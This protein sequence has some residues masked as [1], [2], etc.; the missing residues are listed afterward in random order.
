MKWCLWVPLAAEL[1]AD[2]LENLNASIQSAVNQYDEVLF[3]CHKTVRDHKRRVKYA[4]SDLHHADLEV[5][6]ATAALMKSLGDQHAL[7]T[8]LDAGEFKRLKHI[9]HCDSL[10][11]S[12]LDQLKILKN[13]IDLASAMRDLVECGDATSKTAFAVC[14]EK[15]VKL[16]NQP[17]HP[18]VSSQKKALLEVVGGPKKCALGNNINCG[19]LTDAVSHLHGAA[20]DNTQVLRAQIAAHLEFCKKQLGDMDSSSVL[21]AHRLDGTGS[22]IA[23]RASR[24]VDAR[25][26]QADMH[27]RRHEATQV[28]EDAVSYCKDRIADFAFKIENLKRHR[29]RAFPGTISLDCELSDWLP[30]GHCTV[31]CGGG[32]FRLFTR[33]IIQTPSK[34]G[35]LCNALE[36]TEP[37]NVAAC[38]RDCELAEWDAWTECTAACGGG[39]QRRQRSILKEPANG[40]AVCDSLEEIQQCGTGACGHDQECKLG[41]WAPWGP[42]TRVC[43]DG[44][45]R[46]RKHTVINAAS[47]TAATAAVDLASDNTVN[48]TASSASKACDAGL[49]YGPCMGNPACPSLRGRAAGSKCAGDVDLVLVLDASGS[50]SD[51]AF[52]AQLARAKQLRDVFKPNSVAVVSYSDTATLVVPFDDEKSGDVDGE[53]GFEKSAR[54]AGAR[55][56]EGGTR[57]S[58]GLFK[59]HTLLARGTDMRDRPS[60]VVYTIEAK[61]PYSLLTTQKAFQELRDHG[62]K[63]I[64]VLV[65][66]RDAPWAKEVV[67][68]PSQEHVLRVKSFADISAR[69]I[70]VR[71]CPAI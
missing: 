8:Q 20:R 29:A 5:G 25:K 57:L 66:E 38:P 41:D 24:N 63:V 60:V 3:G 6:D 70:F 67:S 32:G 1:P 55:E 49:E 53:G 35:A 26:R 11:D 69:D 18:S 4:E 13:D 43:G 47:N 46:A 10:K 34:A 64:G 30:R 59:A 7:S 39:T 36:R 14:D 62:V 37:C 19:H 44:G 48:S 33:S 16:M 61:G 21:T 51:A 71:A 42:C 58:Q 52:D 40:G 17:G 22:D 45:L 9:M 31:S 56:E 12:K 68:E 50:V 65:G 2:T 15:L 23:A 54:E 27:V 28:H